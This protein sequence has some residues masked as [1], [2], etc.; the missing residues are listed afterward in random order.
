LSELLE[1]LR[2]PSQ[3]IEQPPAY[4]WPLTAPVMVAVPTATTTMTITM[5]PAMAS[6]AAMALVATA[7]LSS[8]GVPL[9][10]MATL[11][12]YTRLA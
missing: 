3:W 12:A 5:H 4:G 2:F 10:T 1:F 6:A 9:L 7:A 11:T 8:A